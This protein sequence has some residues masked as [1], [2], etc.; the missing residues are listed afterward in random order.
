MHRKSRLESALLIS[1]DESFLINGFK[2]K[3]KFTFVFSETFF[4]TTNYVPTIDVESIPRT[5]SMMLPKP[6]LVP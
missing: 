2:V 1:T 6:S 4:L 3:E 5:H